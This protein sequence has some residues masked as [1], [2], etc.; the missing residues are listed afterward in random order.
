MDQLTD[1]KHPRRCASV[2]SST[3]G[4][5]ISIDMGHHTTDCKASSEVHFCSGKR[6]AGGKDGINVT[7]LHLRI[8]GGSVSLKSGKGVKAYT[9]GQ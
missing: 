6:V 4:V 9:K 7:T 3:T 2:L 5:E 8:L 1:S